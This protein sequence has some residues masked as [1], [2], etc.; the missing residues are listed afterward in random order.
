MNGLLMNSR[1]NA[2][3][4][5]HWDNS[6]NNGFNQGCKPWLS[7][8]THAK[9]INVYNESIDDNSVLNYYKEL[10]KFRKGEFKELLIDGTFTRLYEYETTEDMFVYKK[11]LEND[12]IIVILNLGDKEI[13]YNLSLIENKEILLS[14]YKDKKNKLR[15]FE[16]IV[17]RG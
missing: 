17:V 9:D 6:I 8:N 3:T 14:N 11:S 10:I 2:R 12:S 15:A 5:M 4:P 16:A 7:M 13:E 1:D